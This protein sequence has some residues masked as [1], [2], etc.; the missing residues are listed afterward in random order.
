MQTLIVKN[1]LA[2]YG[3]ATDSERKHGADWYRDAHAIAVDIAEGDAWR[4]AGVIAAL[5]P[6]VKWHINVRYAR[7]AFETGIVT[8]HTKAM[9]AQAQ[10]ILDGEA[11]LDVLKGDKVRAFCAAIATAGE[12]NIATIDRHALEIALGKV[13]SDKERPTIGKKLYR[14][15]SAAYAGAAKSAGISVN[16]MQATTWV[17]W[18]RE[19]GI[20]VA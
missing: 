4:G 18:R 16:A 7:R 12:S 9:C 8:G 1:I 10:R 15:M 3:L 6:R 11:A 13:Y 19:K 20:V 17:V 14:E 2:V 5:S